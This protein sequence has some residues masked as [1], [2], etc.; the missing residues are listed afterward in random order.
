[1]LLLSALMNSYTQIEAGSV[2]VVKQFG[3]VVGVMNPGS[4]GKL[5]FIQN[6]VVYRTQEIIY[7]T[8][9]DPKCQPGRLSGS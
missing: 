5:P 8:S 3:R 7:E 1:M 9:E 2:G 6:V 4:T